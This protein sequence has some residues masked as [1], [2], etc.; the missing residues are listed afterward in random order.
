MINYKL[1]Q[2]KLGHVFKDE[3]LLICALTHRSTQQ[4]E[5]NERL[6][7]LG[8]AVLSLIISTELFSKYAH[9]REGELSRMRAALVKGETIA[10]IA[11]ALGI[12]KVLRLGVG[13]LKSGGKLRESILA[14]AFE[15]VIGA[16]YCDSNYECVKNHVL[17]WYRQ[18]NDKIDFTLDAKDPK[19]IL[20]ELM[21]AQ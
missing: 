8:D 18:Y 19:T 7:F 11:A 15:S 4:S 2:Q 10:K 5:N 9:F 21:Q 13:E 6:E 3:S 14:G 17:Q 16:I 12:G 20:Q 1:L